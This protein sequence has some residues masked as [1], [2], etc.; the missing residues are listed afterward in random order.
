MKW[1]LQ[2]HTPDKQIWQGRTDTTPGSCFFQIVQM[3]DPLRFPSVTS[4]SNAFAIVGFCCDVGIQRN[5]GRTGAAEGPDALRSA[6]AK[7]PV[8]FTSEFVLFDAGNICFDNTDLE[9]AQQALGDVIFWLLTNHITPIVIGGGHEVAFGHYLGLEKYFSSQQQ[10]NFP[11]LGIVNFDA[12]F[13]MRPLIT[14]QYGS[15]GTPFLQIALNHKKNKSKFDYNCIG[16]QKLGNIQSLFD[17]AKQHSTHFL[18]AEDLHLQGHQIAHAFLDRVIKDNQWIYASLCLD[19]FSSAYAPGVSAPQPLGLNPWQVI[20][21]LKQL[22]KSQKVLSY[23]IAELCPRY[24]I[25]LHTTKLAAS[26]VHEIIQSHQKN[27][28]S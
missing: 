12:H 11:P 10:T 14:D 22:C 7:L 5:F 3:L 19:V 2:Y 16:I 25:D 24:D 1:P 17:T 9:S 20:P 15:S 6:L 13:D 26:L 21:L 4:G 8:P 23:D 27:S 18:L 28:I